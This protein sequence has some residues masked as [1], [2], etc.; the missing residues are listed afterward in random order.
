MY[1]SSLQLAFAAIHI[2]R[3]L[4]FA[5]APLQL[6]KTACALVDI[7]AFQRNQP[8]LGDSMCAL[9]AHSRAYHTYNNAVDTIPGIFS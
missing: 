3:E 6:H 4:A 5:V 8:Y 1:D 7:R 9:H 2:P